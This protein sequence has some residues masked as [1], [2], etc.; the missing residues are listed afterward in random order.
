MQALD[1]SAYWQK[2]Y[3]FDVDALSTHPKRGKKL[4]QSF[5][6]LLCINTFVPLQFAYQK[7]LGQSAAEIAI[8]WM[9]QLPAEQ[10]NIVKKFKQFGRPSIDALG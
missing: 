9:E 6:N 7:K 10:N 2:H 4:S 3:N 8:R 5:F 1:I